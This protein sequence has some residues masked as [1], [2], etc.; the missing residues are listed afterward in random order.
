MKIRQPK[1]MITYNVV[2]ATIITIATLFLLVS[3]MIHL[4]MVP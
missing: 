3:S 1:Q 4:M 2:I